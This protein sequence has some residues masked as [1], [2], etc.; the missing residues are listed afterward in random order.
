MNFF[1]KQFNVKKPLKSVNVIIKWW[2]SK[3]L[4]FNLSNLISLVVGILIIYLFDPGL[5]NF[6]LFPFILSYGIILNII[7]FLGWIVLGIIKQT[8][9]DMDITAFS[10]FLFTLFYVVSFFTTIALCIG[11]VIFNIP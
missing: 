2:E 6:F 3:R 8:R 5:I 4:F 7:Y 10:I 9:I 1:I 11:L